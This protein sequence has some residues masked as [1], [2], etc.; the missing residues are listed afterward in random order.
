MGAA[1][2]DRPP[3]PGDLSNDVT[4]DG[5]FHAVRDGYQAVYQALP[6]GEAFNRIWREHAYRGEFPIEFAHI[7][8]LALT[9]A[10][11]L[12]ELLAVPARGVVADLACGGG[13]P[14]LWVA[15][16]TG[17]TLVGVDPA[18]SGLATARRRAE[19]VGLAARSRFQRGTFEQ[20]GLADGE[21]D[22]IMSIEAFQYAPSK[23]AAL[24]EFRRILRPG[25]RVAFVCFEVDP[26]LAGGLPVL[27]V[28]PVA[29]YRPLL[30][31][32]G[33]AVDAYEETPG[34]QERVYGVFQALID[35][36]DALRAE[37]GEQ[38]AS[39]TLA[40]AMLTVAVKPYPRR[41]LAVA[42]AG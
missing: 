2:N 29:D 1:L 14:G 41:I 11:R 26:A 4:G 7:G 8:F 6:R 39:G 23:R 5:V 20:T 30:E 31:A 28:D 3:V 42:T 37:L 38:A 16:Q 35:A 13:G 36:A 40:E 34:W 22:A 19:A 18:E 17:A 27:G 25:R 24:A 10:Q 21:V 9:E 12:V 15:R 32:A 33:F